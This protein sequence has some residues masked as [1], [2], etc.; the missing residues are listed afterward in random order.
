MLAKTDRPWQGVL[1]LDAAADRREPRP[2]TRGVT[3]VIDT[4][5]GCAAARD[6]LEIAAPHIDHWKFGFGTSA[7][8][9]RDVLVRKLALLAEHDVLALPGGT[10]LEA[11]I[12]QQHCRVYMRQA[13]ALGFGAVEIS[14]GTIALS[15]ERRRRVIDCAR[16]AGLVPITE[17]GKKDPERQPGAAELAEQA[18]LDFEWGAAWVVVEAR[19]S[20]RGIGIYDGDGEVRAGFLNEIAERL[21]DLTPRLIWE[22]PRKEQQAELVRR[23]GPNVSLGNVAVN[24]AVALAALRSGLRYETLSTIAALEY[25]A[26][27]WHPAAVE[28]PE[29]SAARDLA[30]E[31]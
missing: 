30:L 6:L 7:M 23:F 11:A 16:D 10:L 25:A 20:G 2:R 1:A 14:D 28:A 17:V 5:I 4:G 26:G 19:E 8:I 18:A 13:R 15:P 3:M 31:R 24:E 9:P 12:V 29:P 27:Q 22:A 21:G